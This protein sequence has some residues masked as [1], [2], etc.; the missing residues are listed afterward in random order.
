MTEVISVRFRG[1]CKN[2]Y[3]DP[4]GLQVKMGDKVIVSTAQGPEFGTCTLSNHEVD[5][6]AIVKPLCAVL[7]K[8]TESDFRTVE[9][10]KKKESEAFDIC[11]KK[12]EDHGLEMKLV[13]CPPALTATRSFSTLPQTAAWISAN[14]YGI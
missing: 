1:G 10:N 6:E 14:W 11:E 13:K 4:K 3:F 12:I 5:D 9:Y 2:Y 7:R 8:A